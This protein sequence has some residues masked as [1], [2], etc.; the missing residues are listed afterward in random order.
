MGAGEEQGVCVG[1]G[2]G[3]SI[4]VTIEYMQNIMSFGKLHTH[5]YA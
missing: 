2:R 4:F 5:I 1:G 3:G